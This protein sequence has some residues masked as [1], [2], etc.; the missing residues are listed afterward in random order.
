MKSGCFFISGVSKLNMLETKKRPRKLL[1]RLVETYVVCFVTQEVKKYGKAYE[2]IKAIV[3][4]VFELAIAFLFKQ[5]ET[6]TTNFQK[7][8]QKNYSVYNI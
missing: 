6:L 7:G 4:S 3:N 8:I 5:A 2:S 1:R